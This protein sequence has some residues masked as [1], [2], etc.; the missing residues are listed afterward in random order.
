[1]VT[2]TVFAV[3]L[4]Q[5][6]VKRVLRRKNRDAERV[7]V[8]AVIR[9]AIDVQRMWRGHSVRMAYALV[10]RQRRWSRQTVQLRAELHAAATAPVV[11]RLNLDRRS[12]APPAP[13]LLAMLAP[14]GIEDWGDTIDPAG[15]AAFFEPQKGFAS[16][17]RTA[18][19][20]LLLREAP[21]PACPMN[22]SLHATLRQMERED[23]AA[24]AAAATADRDP[25]RKRR[26]ESAALSGEV[27]LRREVRRRRSDA[28]A[29]KA[30]KGFISGVGV[31]DQKPRSRTPVWQRLVYNQFS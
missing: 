21:R 31:D 14:L 8:A 12:S 7:R 30:T 15:D 3:M 20:K 9:A 11:S 17:A 29:L 16:M 2:G 28:R 27:L 4:I 25:L 22:V 18:D 24:A 13:S 10:L 1:M 23:R 19:G 26:A 5:R 6:W